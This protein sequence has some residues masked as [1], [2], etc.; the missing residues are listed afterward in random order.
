VTKSIPQCKGISGTIGALTI[1]PTFQDHEV[2]ISIDAP[3]L[4]LTR[5]NDEVDNS[6]IG[7][8]VEQSENVDNF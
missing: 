2:N 4:N 7:T 6:T 5:V 8:R 3:A 1:D